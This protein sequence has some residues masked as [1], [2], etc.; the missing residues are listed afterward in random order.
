MNVTAPTR[1]WHPLLH[2]E[3][4]RRAL[5]AVE[6]V[7]QAL[8]ELP[9]ATPA[10][11]TP[12]YAQ[13]AMPS[14]SA[15]EAGYALFYAY[16]D[17]YKAGTGFAERALAHLERAVDLVATTEGLPDLYSGFT[18]VA[19]TIEHLRGQLL[20]GDEEDDPNTEVDATLREHLAQSPWRGE[21][22]L[23]SGL[24]GF[25]VYAL[26]RLPRPAAVDCLE[27]VV[28]RLD[29]LAVERP[30]GIAWHT[31]ANQLWNDAR[32]HFPHGYDNL[33]V[34]H[35][36]PG[37][38][39]VLARIAAE[40]IAVSRS[41]RLL[42]GAVRWLL[43]QKLAAGSDS[44]FPYAVG[45]GATPRAARAAWC[46]G[47]PGV[48]AALLVAARAIGEPAWE[49]EALELAR[50]AARRPEATAGIK[51]ACLCHG[52]A[53]LGHLFNRFYQASGEELFGNAAR[54]WFRHALACRQGGQG[55]AGFLNWGP[56]SDDEMRWLAEP[57]WLMGAAGV[58][59]ALLA[60]AT[61]IEPHWDE[62]LLVSPC[63]AYPSRE[64]V[65]ALTP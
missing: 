58:A 12:R 56:D 31:D 27:L 26:A 47:D 16:L 43:G 34:A 5:D 65:R 52:S 28:D 63:P 2:G 32:D 14:V 3:T 36:V 9:T 48:A 40:G 24:V 10:D 60:A 29:E 6:A 8:A 50:T 1:H 39:A 11:D 42:E 44:V 57:S 37:V 22:D 33:G 13:L 46:Y 19:W 7:V 20:E 25:A 30:G 54:C 23:T 41:R 35:G 4:A 55:C 64:I 17:R 21:Y 15:G 45:P 59:L 62:L 53:G 49:E 51:D 18:G 38:I 61:G